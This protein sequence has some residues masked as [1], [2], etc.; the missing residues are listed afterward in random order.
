M[1]QGLVDLLVFDLMKFSHDG[2]GGAVNFFIYDTIK[3]LFLLFFMITIIGFLRTFV[4]QKKVKDWVESKSSVLGHFGAAAFGALT[5][6][7][8]CSGIPIFLG[9]IKAGLPLGIVFSFFITSPILN[10][11]LVVLMFSFFGFKIALAYVVTGLLL[12]VISGMI[13]GKLN[14]ERF[15]EKDFLSN[16]TD[17]DK[18]I[19]VNSFKDRIVFGLNEAKDIIAKLWKWIVIGV[20]LGA[21]I[22][23]YVPSELIQEIA[24]KGG[25]FSVPLAVLL[26]VPMYGSCAAIVPIAVVLFQKGLPLGTALAFMM[27]ISALSLPEAVILRKAMTFKLIAVFFAV[28][29]ISII[30]I[31]YLFNFAAPLLI[32]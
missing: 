22:H 26:G 19:I 6:F 28:V 21:V 27:A 20:G 17:L 3:V 9:F 29:T 5:P 23:N 7:C 14:L 1:L 24:G 18:D 32:S 25:I 15:L 10:E 12:G 2:V 4:S 31:G 16:G 13:L 30:I 8:S 11:Y